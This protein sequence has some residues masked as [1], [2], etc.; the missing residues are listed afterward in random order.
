MKNKTAFYRVIFL[1]LSAI[2]L[3][4]GIFMEQHTTTMTKA[5]RICLECIGIG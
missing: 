4:I 2:C 5:I 3:G 1:S